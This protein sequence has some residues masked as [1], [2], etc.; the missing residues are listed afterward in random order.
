MIQHVIDKRIKCRYISQTINYHAR[1]T[2]MGWSL[3]I[4]V[5]PC[6]VKSLLFLFLQ[7]THTQHSR[8][9]ESL[10]DRILFRIKAVTL[11]DITLLFPKCFWDIEANSNIIVSTLIHMD[12]RVA[13]YKNKN[14]RKV[15]F[16]IRIDR[17]Q[18]ILILSENDQIRIC[19]LLH[20]HTSINT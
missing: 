11:F 10:N 5:S 15:V 8:R 14:C 19:R 2:E 20:K 18:R 13:G 7:H 4:P 17:Q 6:S 1:P 16:S 9:L 3:V 12:A